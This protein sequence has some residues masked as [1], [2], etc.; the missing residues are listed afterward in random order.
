[1]LAGDEPKGG[2]SAVPRPPV[3]NRKPWEV[4]TSAEPFPRPNPLKPPTNT[5]P[6]EASGAF[7]LRRET[8]GPPPLTLSR[9]SVTCT[10]LHYAPAPPLEVGWVNSERLRIF[11]APRSGPFDAGDVS[12]PHHQR[13][14]V[15]LSFRSFP[16]GLQTVRKGS[17]RMRELKSPSIPWTTKRHTEA[18]LTPDCACLPASPSRVLLSRLN[19]SSPSHLEKAESLMCLRPRLPVGN[20]PLRPSREKFHPPKYGPL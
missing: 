12:S 15:V 20:L 14:C 10:R 3:V 18:P 17:T 7:P 16:K 8:K 4:S 5:A 2:V 1:M 6:S 9:A 11:Q 19:T 13:G